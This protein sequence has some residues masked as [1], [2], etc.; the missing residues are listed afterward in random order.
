MYCPY[1][2]L[3]SNELRVCVLRGQR[4]RFCDIYGSCF[5]TCELGSYSYVLGVSS[6]RLGH[7]HEHHG[8]HIVPPRVLVGPVLELRI[9]L[10]V[11]V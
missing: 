9:S 4:E 1:E 7:I 11:R 2:V 8:H 5:C 6:S 10:R 3:R